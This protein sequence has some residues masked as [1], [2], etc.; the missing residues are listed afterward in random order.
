MLGQSFV[1][2]RGASFVLQ[3]VLPDAS[4]R[5]PTARHREAGCSGEPLSSLLWPPQSRPRM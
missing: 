3:N 1:P 2:G 5:S 4:P